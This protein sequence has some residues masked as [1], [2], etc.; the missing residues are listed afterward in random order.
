MR[1]AA[2]AWALGGL[3]MGAFGLNRLA[4]GHVLVLRLDIALSALVA[5]GLA[6]Y[7]AA[8]A[9]AATHVPR[10]LVGATPSS[11][12]LA[13][14]AVRLTTDD[15][16]HLAAWYV[17]SGNGAAVVLLHGAGATRSNV[18]NQAAAL[19]RGGFG[20]LLVDARGHGAS[21]GRAMD[22]GWQGDLDV[23]AAT[24]YLAHRDDVAANRIGV[25]GIGLGG[26]EAIGA[27]GSNA[28]IRAVVAEGATGRV[29]GDQAWRSD[30]DGVWGTVTNEAGHVRDWVTGAFT[31][32]AEP[33]TLRAAV[34][35]STGT[36]Y[37]LITGSRVVEERHAADYI[38]RGARSHTHIWTVA[39][40]GHAMGMRVAPLEWER[41]VVAFLRAALD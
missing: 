9:V 6:A 41:R 20:V 27:S 35:A 3:A 26:E 22:F 40:A 19:S 17:P 1:A 5:A 25:V 32:A 8:P 33:P 7:I 11:V 14:S 12:G 13:A 15:G 28:D 38:A 24:D 31:S 39:N 4:R 18:L 16:V 23:A 37:L 21:G 2:V 36:E 34:A 30:V 10:P 29:A